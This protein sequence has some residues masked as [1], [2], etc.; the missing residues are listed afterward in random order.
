M[1]KIIKRK[2]ELISYSEKKES[3]IYR[4]KLTKEILEIYLN[5]VKEEVPYEVD[6]ILYKIKEAE[7]EEDSN[8]LKISLE[9]LEGEQLIQVKKELGVS[10][11]NLEGQI[12]EMSNEGIYV[13]KIIPIID[14]DDFQDTIFEEIKNNN[15]DLEE[16]K[17]PEN[18][19]NKIILEEDEAEEKINFGPYKWLVYISKKTNKKYDTEIQAYLYIE[20][21]NLD[22]EEKQGNNSNN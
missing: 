1:N 14:T 19:R 2:I 16:I 6:N 18:N 7:L 4:E 9:L 21:L 10:Y 11:V 17:Y 8:T 13:E 12:K 22:F 20:N 15:L 5:K 3:L